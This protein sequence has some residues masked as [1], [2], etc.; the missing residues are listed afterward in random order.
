MVCGHA[1]L[2]EKPMKMMK[3]RKRKKASDLILVPL[4][5]R[6]LLVV[7]CSGLDGQTWTNKDCHHHHHHHHHRRHSGGHLLP[8][9][10][11]IPTQ[12]IHANDL[13]NDLKENDAGNDDV[14]HEVA[15]NDFVVHDLDF[16]YRDD[17]Q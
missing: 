5:F 17:V 3:R 11:R 9:L 6:L 15:G 10:L 7:D 8:P 1:T 16:V 12:K 14:V 13:A 4:L 2:R